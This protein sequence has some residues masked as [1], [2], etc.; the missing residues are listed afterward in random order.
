MTSGARQVVGELERAARANEF[1]AHWESKR[2]P[3]LDFTVEND[4]EATAFGLKALAQLAP[5]ARCCRRSR[6]GWLQIDR[7]VTTGRRPNRR[8]SRSSA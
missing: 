8:P 4:I 1:D 3:M 6:D 2:R 7:V 5:E